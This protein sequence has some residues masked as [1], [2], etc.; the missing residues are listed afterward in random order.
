MI[1][2][3]EK[4]ETMP[5]SHS[6]TELDTVCA[7]WEQED[8]YMTKKKKRIRSNRLPTDTNMILGKKEPENV[9]YKSVARPSQTLGTAGTQSLLSPQQYRHTTGFPAAP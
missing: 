6:V 5:K 1:R 3:N 2:P 9:R 8:N 4:K 7:T